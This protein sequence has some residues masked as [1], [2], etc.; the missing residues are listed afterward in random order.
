MARLLLLLWILC[1]MLIAFSSCRNLCSRIFFQNINEENMPYK[2][3]EGVFTKE[4]NNH[5]NFPVYRREN[6]N[7]L[8]YYYISKEGKKYL[9]FGLNLKDYFGVAAAVYSD[10]DPVS[11]LSS[12][13]MDRSD[14][15]GGLIDKWM[16]FNTR[17]KTN[18]YVSV[19]S[20][21]PMIK[22]VCVDEDFIECNSDKLYLNDNFTD[23][24]GNVVNDLT[25]DYFF[26]KQ[27]VFR[28]LRPLYQHS[29]QTWYLQYT[30]DGFWVV[31]ERYSPSN[32][33]DKVLMK[34]KDFALRPEYISKTW[35]VRYVKTGWRYM[36]KLRVLCR[37]VNSMSNTC[38]SKPCN[39]KATCIYTSGNETLC[40]CPSGYTGVTCSTNKQCPTPY[41][42]AGTELNFAYFGKRP[43]DIG[44]SFCG[45]L[46]P[47]VRFSLCRDSNYSN[48]Y[49]FKVG[50]DC[51]RVNTGRTSPPWSSW[52]PGKTQGP[53][54]PPTVRARHNFDNNPIIVSVVLTSVALLELL[55]PFIIY[56]CAVCKKKGKE[57]REEQEDQRRL[58]EVGGELE[59]RLEQVARAGSQEELDRGVKDYQRTVQEYQREDEDKELSRK[60]GLYRNASLWRIISMHLFFSF[61]LWIV[62][63][64][65]CEISQ[66]TQYGRIFV[67]LKTFAIAMLCISS[68]YIFIESLFSNELDYLR[69]IMQ[70]ETAWG[71]IQ[72]M[73]QVAP[74]I[75]MVVECYHFETRTRVVYYTDANG[76]R[77]SRTE[78]YTERVVTFVDH[79]EFSF[80]SWVDISKRE[81]PALSTVS[82]TRVRIDP[83]VLFGD[84]ETADDYERQAAAMMERNRRQD[85]FTDF[86]ASREIPGLKKRISAYVDLRVKPWWIRPLFFWLATLLQMTWPYRWLF[87]AKTSKSY[88]A[89]KKKLYKSKTPPREVDIMDPI[90][91]L[92]GGASSNDCS[93][94]NQQPIK[95]SP[96][97]P[98]KPLASTLPRVDI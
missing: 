86:S 81:M 21:S 39:S 78:T 58:Q 42:S 62:Y 75:G 61:Y 79:D 60:R 27:G 66:C 17:D 83:Y 36:P 10:V 50:G 71:Y 32:S 65:G 3:I 5:N 23:G 24:R 12:G 20:S 6:D 9:A 56:C 85:T 98:Y 89:L 77:Q 57:D 76:N 16:F 19:S 46:Y 8:F 18:Y 88:Y 70:D 51:H 4:N 97:L 28:N 44:F 52:N 48:P 49:W 73:H 7:L 41:P 93:V 64:V 34:T 14:V 90:A 47:S 33:N 35:S 82:L 68:V 2:I 67:Y 30:A 92:A 37:G 69:N 43:G 40:L 95:W 87:R 1:S 74:R 55:V 25:R 45:G 94:P 96:H 72:Q 54:K 31:T 26:R 63:L 84:Q 15:F 80:G 11:W 29:N 13:S 53:W 22:A 91:M 59:R 38:L